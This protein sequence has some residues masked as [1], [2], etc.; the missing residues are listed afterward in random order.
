MRSEPIVAEV[1]PGTAPGEGGRGPEPDVEKEALLAWLDEQR[2]H[3]LGI[4]D[5]LDE[6]AL[7]RPV[8]PSGWSCL[9]MV[10]HLAAL[11]GFW[12]R[13]IVAGEPMVGDG[14]GEDDDEWRVAPD[15]PAAAV[16]AAYRDAAAFSDAVI[17][18]T[19]LDAPPAW[20]PEDLFG[21]WRLRS[22]RE[23]VLHTMT[24]TASHAG[25]LDAVREL[26]DGR[27]WLVLDA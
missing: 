7:R 4:L 2:Q 3:A 1:T 14:L 11:E 18:A 25:H 22:V 16:F 15:V 21:E 9:G 24:E 13:A 20:W 27:L 19:P 17:T 23:I 5:G 12:F 10:R 26:I 6:E 8:L